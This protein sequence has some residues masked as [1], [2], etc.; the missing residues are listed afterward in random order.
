MKKSIL[1][2][3]ISLLFNGIVFSQIPADFPFKTFVDDNNY[4]YI[5]GDSLGEIWT[6]RY[7]QNLDR[8]WRNIFPNPGFD[9]GMDITIYNNDYV[10]VCGYLQELNSTKSNIVLIKYDNSS[11]NIIW[12]KTFGNQDYDDKAYGIAIDED[13]NTYIAGYVTE[14]K[15][16]KDLK[17]LKYDL[18]GN[19]V[20]Q[21][22]YNNPLYNSDDVATDILIDNNYFYAAGYTYEGSHYSNDIMLVSYLLENPSSNTI[23]IHKDKAN[24]TPTGVVLTNISRNAY[25]KSRATITG[26]SDNPSNPGHSE[27]FTVMFNNDENSTVRWKRTFSTNPHS[28]N[29]STAITKD[30]SDNLYVTGYCY[31]G[32]AQQFDFATIKYNNSDGTNGWPEDS[33]VYFDS[34]GGNDKATSVKARGDTIYIAGPCENAGSGFYIGRY[35]THQAGIVLNAERVFIPAFCEFAVPSGMK[36]A[37]TIELDS[38]GN[39][40]LVSFAWNSEVS[41]Y[42]IRKYDS[43]MN[44]LYTIDNIPPDISAQSENFENGNQVNTLQEYKLN[45]NYPNPF[46]PATKINYELRIKNYE[47][48]TLKIYNALGKEVATLVNQN[49]EAGSYESEFNASEYPSG[50]YFYSLFVDNVLIDTKRM[51]LVK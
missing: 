4:L 23:T 24:Y 45:Q 34:L 49:Q 35:S 43:E 14:K 9:K 5:T 37:A 8:I 36:T 32:P 47:F 17:V 31:R 10:F 11:G 51:L 30:R 33:E 6:A 7:N 1:A 29:A 2:I 39:S 46:N 41:Y 40:Y 13:M 48:V 19:I 18:S 3:S 50:M 16:G 28:I 12:Y 44:V 15:K 26:I 22:K 20:F 21:H 42:A 27:F 25:T 38:L